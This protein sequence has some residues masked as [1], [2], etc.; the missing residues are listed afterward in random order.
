MNILL[1][2]ELEDLVKRKVESGAYNDESEVVADALRRMENQERH[3]WLREAVGKGLQDID[4]GNTVEMTPEL[5]EEMIQ[6][7][8]RRA[9]AGEKPSADVTP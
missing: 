2:P 9:A 8:I 3:A 5:R 1:S 4:Q 7:A 6:N